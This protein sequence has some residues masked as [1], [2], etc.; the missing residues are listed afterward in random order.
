MAGSNTPYTDLDFSQ[1]LRQSFEEPNDVLRVKPLAGLVVPPWDYFNVSY[2]SST[3]TI[4]HYYTNG[5]GGTL[6]ATATINYTDATQ[7]NISNFTL[8]TP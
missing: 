2:P 7:A 3:Q 5:S 4:Y 1:V 8:T 6:V